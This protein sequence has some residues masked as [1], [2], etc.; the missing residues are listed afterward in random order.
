MQT[1]HADQIAGSLG[2]LMRAAKR[3]AGSSADVGSRVLLFRLAD[4]PLRLTELA[5]QA[6]LDASTASRHVAALETQ[7]LV[8]REPDPADGRARVL[9]LTPDG[10]DAVARA[11][12]E[13]IALL[14]DLLADWSAADIEQ[15]DRLLRKLAEQASSKD[16]A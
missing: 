3:R 6:H 11:R 2:V 12:A 4:G 10:R 9:T 7:G 15:L 8:V 14:N 16:H 1:N 13:R 5:A